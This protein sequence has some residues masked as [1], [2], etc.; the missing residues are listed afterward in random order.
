M[1]E[2]I[3]PR[4]YYNALLPGDY[5]SDGKVN[6]ADYT[7]IEKGRP[8]IDHYGNIDFHFGK[9]LDDVTGPYDEK[10]LVNRGGGTWT[11]QAP[12][13]YENFR[14]TGGLIV[15][16]ANNVKLRNFEIINPP[17]L[18]AAIKFSSNDLTGGLIE[19]GEISGGTATNAIAGSNY[20]ARRLNIHQMAADC[21]R[22][23]V[24]VTLEESWLH[25]FGN[26]PDA[27]GD[28]VQ[29]YP[30]TGGNMT[31]RHNYIDAGGANA[32][33]FQVN[34]G[35]T[36]SDNV[37]GGGNYTIQCG[38]EVGNRFTNNIFQKNAKYGPIRV[39]SGDEDLLTWSNNTFADG[40]AIT[41]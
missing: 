19:Y 40:T 8:N 36:V 18:G 12:G 31:I 32:A 5:N 4:L 21:L 13:T 1:I 34:G 23:K 35:W 27:H 41:L 9:S 30:T 11:I 20:T 16:T 15:I 2:P 10:A 39:G 24:N 22:V 28:G 33:L 26:A 29:M 25:D 37:F 6:A 14:I 17:G 3:E 7:H 38:G